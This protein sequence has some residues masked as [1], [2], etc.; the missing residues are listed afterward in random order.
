MEESK[1]RR[2]SGS[3]GWAVVAVL[4]GATACGGGLDGLPGNSVLEENDAIGLADEDKADGAWSWNRVWQN[5]KKRVKDRVD[6]AR[7][8]AESVYDQMLSIWNRGVDYAVNHPE[9]IWD[10]VR[11]LDCKT[12]VEGVSSFNP[13]R[14]FL[15]NFSAPAA[16]CMDQFSVGFVCGTGQMMHALRTV[17]VGSIRSAWEHR[18]ACF[19]TAILAGPL[20]GAGFALCGLYYYAKPQVV[21]MARCAQQ[22]YRENQ[23]WRALWTELWHTGCE[24]AGQMTLDVVMEALSGGAGTAAMIGSWFFKIKRLISPVAWLRAAGPVAHHSI[25]AVAHSLINVSERL[26]ECQDD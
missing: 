5:T 10:A 9:E 13:A 17:A 4:M 24:L 18:Q 6:E 22:L 14:K 8:R 12:V 15:A 11:S 2:I 26:S 16:T 21:K 7:D 19:R 3:K 20:G 1:V 23:L 25:E